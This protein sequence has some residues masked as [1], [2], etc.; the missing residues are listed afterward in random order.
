MGPP[1]RTP[2]EQAIVLV[3]PEST[4]QTTSAGLVPQHLATNGVSA[5]MQLTTSVIAAVLF[6]ALKALEAVGDYEPCASE[7]NKEEHGNLNQYTRYCV[8]MGEYMVLGSIVGGSD[9]S[10]FST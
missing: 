1:C 3:S 10:V 2:L 5:G 8:N 9:Y 7:V 6:T 4:R